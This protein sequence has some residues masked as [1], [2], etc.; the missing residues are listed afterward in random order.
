MDIIIKDNL[1]FI[2]IPRDIRKPFLIS[3]A[4]EWQDR[5]KF[6]EHYV[7]DIKGYYRDVCLNRYYCDDYKWRIIQDKYTGEL[8]CEIDD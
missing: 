3:E 1:D 8:G 4:E 5:N 2:E 6:E 7:D